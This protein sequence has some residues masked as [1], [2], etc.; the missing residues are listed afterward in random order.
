MA[1]LTTAPVSCKIRWRRLRRLFTQERRNS[2]M[3]SHAATPIPEPIDG[4]LYR[5]Y[6]TCRDKD[7]RS[8]AAYV[9][10][11]LFDDRREPVVCEQPL[12]GPGEVGGFDDSGAGLSC[13]VES[14]GEKFLYYVGWNLGVTVPFRNSIGLARWQ[15]G[16][17]LPRKYSPAPVLDRNAIDPFHLSYPFVLRDGERWRMWYGSSL[18]WSQHLADM[19]HVVKYAESNDGI[20]WQPTGDIC[21]PLIHEGEIAVT[22]PCVIR[23]GGQ[24]EM[25]FAYKGKDFDY[26]LG[27]A[28]SD[29]GVRWTRQDEAATFPRPA[30]DWDSD[31]VCYPCVFQHRGEWYM[32]YCGNGYGRSGFGLAVM[33]ELSQ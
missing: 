7:N 31:M 33:E 9:E 27:W 14:D 19:V 16:E 10:L 4:E 32:L 21:V 23:R 22:R 29:D 5:I 20:R 12:L 8:H 30:G 15:A 18:N 17:G 13:I 2:W 3:W 11:D 24:W 6:F 28:V 1:L 25:W 26:R